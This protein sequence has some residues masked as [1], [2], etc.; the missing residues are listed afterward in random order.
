HGFASARKLKEGELVVVDFGAVYNGYRSDITRTYIVVG[1][2]GPRGQRRR[3]RKARL[4]GIV[5]AAQR[6]AIKAV[7]S[8]VRACDVDKV[9]RDYLIKQGFGKQF[10]HSTGHG[11]GKRVHQAP[12]IGPR[13]KNRLKV[14]QVVCIEPGV[15]FKGYGGV[16]WEDMFVVTKK[17]CWAL[18]K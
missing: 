18:T 1:E 5:R 6:K 14:G 4:I 3:R 13:N 2:K 15:Y 11:V 16:R 17:G 12:K 7:K 9:A 10:I 8:G